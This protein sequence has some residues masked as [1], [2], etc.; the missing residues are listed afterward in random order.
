MKKITAFG[1]FLILLTITSCVK[2]SDLLTEGEPEIIT[3]E[4]ETRLVSG[5][6][7]DTS[8]T[9]LGD[10]SVK[11]IVDDLEMA[12]TADENGEWSLIVPNTLTEGYVVANKLE[13]SKSIQRLME[14]D[15][16]LAGDIFLAKESS[17]TE[18]DL[19][20][21]VSTLKTVTGRVVDADGN[22]IPGV[23]LFIMSVIDGPEVEFDLTGF[24]LTDMDGNFEII[25]EDEGYLASNLWGF[26]SGACNNTLFIPIED[27]N[28]V[29]DLGDL[30]IAYENFS[31][32]E[33]SL[34]SDGSSCYDDARARIFNFR[35]QTGY[36]PVIWDQ[37][38]GD[39]GLQYCPAESGVFYVG[40]ESS[41]RSYFNGAFMIEDEVEPSYMFDIC[42]PTE[43]SFLELNLGGDDILFEDVVFD[44]IT[45][46]ISTE[47]DNPIIFSTQHWATFLPVGED[48]SA[49]H[50]E[51]L[52]FLLFTNP[53]GVQYGLDEDSIVNYVSMVQD[54][55]SFCAG[56]VKVDLVGTDGSLV[57]ANIRFR[58]SK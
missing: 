3:Q 22:P 17:N 47:G 4:G 26:Y 10:A 27:M 42:T 35:S 36:L 16:N 6:V 9:V 19:S 2:E 13:Y 33:T 25:F 48:F 32:F 15:E 54:D 28:P 11:I 37:P 21:N 23:S 52:N 18:L 55:A 44:P 8:G 34:E 41:D 14:T 38:L 5:I 56:V 51:K 45:Q 1:I 24:V 58:A 31:M 53:G 57:E 7:R 30:E 12:T 50:I 29:V 39:I 43:G 20:L 49:Y 46:L 40:V